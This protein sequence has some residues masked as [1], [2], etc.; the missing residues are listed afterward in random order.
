MDFDLP[1]REEIACALDTLEVRLAR[2]GQYDGAA[3][4]GSARRII[5]HAEEEIRELEFMVFWAFD[6]IA[7][8]VEIMTNDQLGTWLGVRAWQEHP[9]VGA[10][11]DAVRLRREKRRSESAGSSGH[12][13]EKPSSDSGPSATGNT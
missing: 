5:R 1:D 9:S 2:Q 11:V 4:V 6:V 13:A 10:A 12:P 3:D 7:R 8:G